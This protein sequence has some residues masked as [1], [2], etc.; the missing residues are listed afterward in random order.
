M[1]HDRDVELP[2]GVRVSRSVIYT[3]GTA[4]VAALFAYLPQHEG[5]TEPGR[6]ALFVLLT[7][8]SWWI[9]GAIPAFAVSLAVIAMQIALL[10][11]PSGPFA[12]GDVERWQRFISPWASPVMWLFLS[13]LVLAAAATRTGLDRRLAERVLA[14][15]GTAPSRVLLAVMS[16]TFVLSMFM[17]NTAT[18]AM[19]IALVL[20][21]PAVSER[22]D[23]R[24]DRYATALL[25]GI[26]VAANIGG[27][28]TIIGT[29][30]NAI[31][32]TALVGTGR[33]DF[34]TWMLYG[35]PPAL[36]LGTVA[37][38]YLVGRYLKDT[39]AAAPASPVE[40]T[41]PMTGRH[42]FVAVLFLITVIAWLTESLHGIPTAVVAVMPIAVLAVS[43]V[44]RERDVRALP[45]DVLM[46]IAGGLSLGVGVSETGLAEWLV[47]RLPVAGLPAPLLA[48]LMALVGT[49]LSTFISNTAAATILTPLAVAL[50]GTDA[51]LVVVPLALA[52]SASMSLPVSTPPNAIAFAT[53]R[54]PREDLRRVGLLLGTITPLVAIGWS[55]TVERL[56]R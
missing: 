5:L 41:S 26:P 17:S 30:P 44:I 13:G 55:W 47:G 10:G 32:A 20:A 12:S 50:A 23:A 38:R 25:L 40:P 9:T 6:H 28:G 2:L 3:V 34:A 39:A 14:L 36:L 18:T 43:G 27:M 35:L 46:L 21:M 37:W 16:V 54:I 11:D 51:R 15:A 8:A 45:W 48:L 52:M 29:P 22:G 7:A 49:L 1:R 31:A 4:T 24:A 42:V 33:L 19:M 56:L 53:E